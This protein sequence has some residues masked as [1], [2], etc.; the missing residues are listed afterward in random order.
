MDMWGSFQK[1]RRARGIQGFPTCPTSASPAFPIM[2]NGTITA[3]PHRNVGIV[4]LPSCSRGS[5]SRPVGA[6]LLNVYPLQ[7]TVASFLEVPTS[8]LRAFPSFHCRRTPVCSGHRSQSK[9]QNKSDPVTFKLKEETSPMSG[10]GLGIWAC[11]PLQLHLL[12][13]P[14]FLLHQP[15]GPSGVPG[16]HQTDSCVQDF[17]S[18]FPLPGPLFPWGCLA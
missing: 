8:L 9:G 12:P 11:Q 15:R 4:F 10:C 5:L 1:V 6:V 18:L 2:A 14:S 17:A 16:R 3:L 13:L 7:A